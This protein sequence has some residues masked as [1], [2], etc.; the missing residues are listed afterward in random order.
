VTILRRDPLRG[1]DQEHSYPGGVWPRS[2]HRPSRRGSSTSTP[3]ASAGPTPARSSSGAP[4]AARN[5]TAATT[6][7]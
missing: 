1:R 4:R 7:T 6:P 3:F 5:S 2:R